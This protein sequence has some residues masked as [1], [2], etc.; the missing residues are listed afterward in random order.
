[1]KKRVGALLLIVLLAFSTVVTAAEPVPTA[2]AVSNLVL[3]ETT[4]QSV[5]IP[6]GGTR[7][8]SMLVKLREGYIVNPQFF[9]TSAD[10]ESLT[11]SNIKI[12]DPDNPDS[13][14]VFLS[15]TAQAL[16]EY[17]VKADD[18]AKIGT[19]KYYITYTAVTS[20]ENAPE[21]G[22]LEMQ[23]VVISE[24]VPPQISVISGTE[25]SANAGENVTMT[26][27]VRNEGELKALNTY[28]SVGY[29]DSIMIPSYAPL[30]QKVGDIAARGT[31][32][33][34]V[35]Y[36]IN[37]DVKTQRVKL[38]IT[39]VYKN[40]RGENFTT[41]DYALYLDIKGV[42]S[43]SDGSESSTL[44][45]NTVSQSP[46]QPIAGGD[47]TVSFHLE[48]VGNKDI[49]DVKV[50]AA[51]LSAAG[52]EPIN[53]EP[54]QYIGTIPGN[55]RKKVDVS[56][57]VGKEIAEGLN[58]LTIQYTYTDGNG[59]QRS[60][61]TS[62][63]ILDVKNPKNDEVVISRPKL[64]VSNFFTDLEEVKAG[65]IFDFT[66]NIKNTNADINAKN[67]KV[68]VTSSSGTFSVT[69]GS[70]SFFVDQIKAGG[71]AAITVNLK[72][73]AA[74]TTGAY[75]INI[76]ME[77][78]YDGM[79]A[80][81]TYDGEVVNEEILLQVKENLRPSVENVSV[82]GWN[83][84][85]VNQTTT[86]NFEFYNMGKSIL[87]NTYVTIEGDFMLANGSNSYYI[88][89]ISAGMPEYVEFDVIPLVEGT[90]TGKMIIHMEDS[91]GDE[92]TLEKDFSAYI[93]GENSGNYP[94][95][96][97]IVIDPSIPTD[98]NQVVKE[99]ILPLWMF[100]CIQ[101]AILVIVI[102]VTR[103]IRLTVYRSRIRKEDEQ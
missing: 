95:G 72:A 23:A 44:L 30:N 90:A 50:S 87:N 84:P 102:P 40:E 80:T 38:P 70:N 100:L 36:T 20:E 41:S 81:P 45:L 25:F 53:S 51:G 78:E 47:I 32:Q 57:K 10:G 96:D 6:A 26:F 13:P 16:L 5:Q 58:T 49:T 46:A 74:V 11:F 82:G 14:Y 73:S 37:E 85:I 71:T 83:S 28:L 35:S 94:G 2:G 21:P 54:Y 22:E 86:M 68:T 97:D 93:Q 103:K 76:K 29:D 39:V 52:F 77:Y 4:M 67:I 31:K 17:D 42:G 64:M 99:P 61:S 88:G 27:T 33:V 43:E 48:N 101:A 3:G 60:E 8:V 65:S 55:S 56:L 63:Y 12:S 15:D 7:H 98:N 1:M 66:F 89:N 18:Y 59:I 24:K 34:T 91:N 62:L 75:P 19:Y 92:V 69:A 79:V 9:V